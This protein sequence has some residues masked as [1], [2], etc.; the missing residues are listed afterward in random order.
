MQKE[1]QDQCPHLKLFPGFRFFLLYVLCLLE[2]T[3][4]LLV[5]ITC[6]AM[7]MFGIGNN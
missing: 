6:V 7:A 3:V 5:D 2:D 1:I 4:E